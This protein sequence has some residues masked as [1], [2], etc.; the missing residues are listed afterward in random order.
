MLSERGRGEGE[1][2][3]GGSSTRGGPEYLV[4]EKEHTGAGVV[5]LVHGVEIRHLPDIHQINHCK[6]F[7]RVCRGCQDLRAS[8]HDSISQHKRLSSRPDW[9]AAVTVVDA[10]CFC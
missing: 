8:T 5:Q 2:G 4:A 1:G 10:R 9:Q 7:Y 6:V 3:W